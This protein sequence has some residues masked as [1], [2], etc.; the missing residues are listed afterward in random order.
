MN[1]SKEVGYRIQK[2]R[3]KLGYT[4][5]DLADIISK[6]ISISEKQISAI[7]RG[8]SG[9]SLANYVEIFVTLK[10]TPDYFCL[11]LDRGDAEGTD[12]DEE[13][14]ELL[15]LCSN[16]DKQYFKTVVRAFLENSDN[17]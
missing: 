7:E 16:T 4:Q 15:K 2:Q 1:F 11:G 10:K 3:R 6:K 9:T 13:I 8:V 17:H 14:L 5:K 12:T